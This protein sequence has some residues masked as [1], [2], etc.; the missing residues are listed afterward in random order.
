[1]GKAEGLK[2]IAIP[3]YIIDSLILMIAFKFEYNAIM[4]MLATYIT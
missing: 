2:D 3:Q 1:M 4:V